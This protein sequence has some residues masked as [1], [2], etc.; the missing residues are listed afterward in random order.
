MIPLL[1]LLLGSALAEPP[2][3]SLD[4]A[5]AAAGQ[6]P[7]VLAADRTRDAAWAGVGVARPG[8]LPSFSL[9]G[10]VLYYDS[11][12]TFSL[13]EGDEPMDCSA[14]P[15][16]FKSMCEG[17]ATPTVV[18]EQLTT[19]VTARAVLPLTGQVTADRQIA[20]AKANARAAD[21]TERAAEADARYN[22]EDAWYAALEA[23]QQL[24]IANSQVKSLSVRV[25]AAKAA[26]EA[27]SL[28]RSDLL[29]ASIALSQAQ[30]AVIQL[31]AL[32]DTAYRRLGL[33]MGNGGEPVRPDGQ[34][35]APIRPPPDVDRLMALA[36]DYRPDLAAA[37]ERAKA[38]RASAQ[39]TSWMRLPTINAMGAYTHQTGQGVFSEPDVGYVG[40]SLD[41]PVFTWGK[42]MY[43]ARA[44]DD[45]A[46]AAA[47]QVELVKGALSVEIHSRAD[48]LSTAIAGLAV[49]ETVVEQAEENLHIQEARQGAGGAT[50]Q[51]VLDA[52]TT[53]V[54]AQS[55]RASAE[56]AARRAEA[57]LER[58]VG[59]DPWQS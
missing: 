50:M 12:Q 39:A 49:G 10:N 45:N 37:E 56:F 57:A 29:L 31:T 22:A 35:T 5:I 38:A 16:A 20:A 3:V 18:R 27:G 24:A 6:H 8:R 44:A 36:V 34:L 2:A 46:D 33:A 30:Q 7:S 42:A 25:D 52:E 17:F 28:I 54:K 41:W 21:A 1:S 4:Q 13:V 15:D 40:A 14:F 26:V 58:A 19:S 51:E 55:S 53:L 47:L 32:R 9:S 11:E 48:A 23:E 59:G 43:A